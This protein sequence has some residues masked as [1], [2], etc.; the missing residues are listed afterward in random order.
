[1]I[2]ITRKMYEK[3]IEHSK[4]EVP[5]EACGYLSGKNGLILKLYEMEN[6]DKSSEHFSMNPRE[7]FHAVKEI[8]KEK[9]E[10]YGIYHSHPLT[11]SRPS[12]EDIRLAYDPDILYFIVSLSGETPVVN[13]FWIKEGRVEKEEL[14]VIDER[15]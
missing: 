1:M 9:M 3:M 14:E 15:I 8:R 10:L 7:Q 11:P 4:K 2:Q 6:L 13:A 5:I 12:E